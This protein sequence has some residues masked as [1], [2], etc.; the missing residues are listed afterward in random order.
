MDR[1]HPAPAA[2]TGTT[3]AAHNG[4]SSATAPANAP[5]LYQRAQKGNL[6]G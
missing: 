5:L 6:N 4:N 2:G 3:P 1:N